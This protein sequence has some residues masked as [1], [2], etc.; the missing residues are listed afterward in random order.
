[1]DGKSL[2]VCGCPRSSHN[3]GRDS[4]TTTGIT[5]IVGGVGGRGW[6]CKCKG[7]RQSIIRMGDWP[8]RTR[9]TD[10][11]TSHDAEARVKAS[12]ERSRHANAVLDLVSTFGPANSS[13][14]A[15]H[16]HKGLHSDYFQ[17]REQIRRRLGELR[18]ANL[19]YDYRIDGDRELTW[20]LGPAPEEKP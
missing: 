20:A 16:E 6:R 3:N 7:F 18:D 19:I 15:R 14:L 2:C 11:Q 1:M 9:N 4:C 10:P 5:P 12:G 17:R 13:A 8:P